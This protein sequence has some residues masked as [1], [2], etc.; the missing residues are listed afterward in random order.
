M[1]ATGRSATTIGIAL[2]IVLV[3]LGIAS[4]VLSDFASL[5]ALIPTLFG[6]LILILS[7]AGRDEERERL[8][9]LGVGALALL[10]ILG[11]LRG[12]PDIVA[13]LSG[14]SVD[15]VIGTVSQGLM[16]L[17]SLILLVVVVYYVIDTQ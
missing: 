17:I 2:G 1:T 7:V 4:Y 12:V 15:S 16:I 5:T 6:I 3:V 11:S 8:A 14:E 13:Y 10:G 9:L